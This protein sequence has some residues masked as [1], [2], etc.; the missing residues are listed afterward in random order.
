MHLTA[1]ARSRLEEMCT[2]WGNKLMRGDLSGV[3]SEGGQILF[4]CSWLPLVTI[5]C[6]FISQWC[7]SRSLKIGHPSLD[8][9]CGFN[10][11]KITRSHWHL[12]PPL[13]GKAM[14]SCFITTS[15]LAI[16][17]VMVHIGFLPKLLFSNV[18]HCLWWPLKQV[19]FDELRSWMLL[20]GQQILVNKGMG[21]KYKSLKARVCEGHTAKRSAL[22]L[23][24]H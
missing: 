15:K 23:L 12:A 4:C 6:C 22:Y 3:R 18:S 11:R 20:I 21:S 14:A 9:L 19:P 7:L 17:V 1:L 13:W 8:A 2:T 16:M 5:V 10:P 24:P